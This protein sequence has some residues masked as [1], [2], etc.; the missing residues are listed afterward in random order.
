MN[1]GDSIQATEQE[2]KQVGG[3]E[4]GIKYDHNDDMQTKMVIDDGMQL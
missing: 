3:T 4:Y 2:I 1:L